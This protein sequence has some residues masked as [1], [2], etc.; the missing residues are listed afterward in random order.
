M[1]TTLISITNPL[2]TGV[3]LVSSLTNSKNFR[4]YCPPLVEGAVPHRLEGLNSIH[5]D[6]LQTAQIQIIFWPNNVG[7]ELDALLELSN[8]LLGTLQY[9]ISGV[10]TPSSRMEPC[11]IGCSIGEI[12]GGVIDIVNPFFDPITMSVR[13]ETDDGSFTVAN[14][15]KTRYANGMET[16]SVH[17]S[18]RATQMRKSE[19]NLIVEFDGHIWIYPIIGIPEIE[20][21]PIQLKSKSRENTEAIVDLTITQ[22]AHDNFKFAWHNHFNMQLEGTFSAIEKVFSCK[23][24]EA[25]SLDSNSISLKLFV[26]HMN[27]NFS[28]GFLR[29]SQWTQK[30]AFVLPI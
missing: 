5:L 1:K 13:L 20:G 28:Y 4:I 16:S 11:Y 7:H 17:F 2:A 25:V 12:K 6:P 26:R 9:K 8:P 29:L 22:F 24:L 21:P 10:G 14:N 15:S 18:Y 19:A 30:F 23:V 27:I 3:S